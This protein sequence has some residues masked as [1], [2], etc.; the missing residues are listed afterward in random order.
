[1][2]DEANEISGPWVDPEGSSAGLE[3]S[4]LGSTWHVRFDQNTGSCFLLTDLE[5]GS[6]AAASPT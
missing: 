2:L 3:W 6:I 4:F 5:L 1:M